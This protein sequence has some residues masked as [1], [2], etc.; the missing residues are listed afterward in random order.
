MKKQWTASF[1]SVAFIISNLFFVMPILAA[2]ENVK[3]SFNPA[4]LIPSAEAATV[5][6]TA[7]GADERITLD[8]KGVDILDVLKIIGQRTQMNVIAGKNVRGEV[9]LFLNDVPI[10]EALDTI[11]STLDLSYSQ[12]G[13]IMNVMSNQAFESAYG[14]S[15]ESG[16]VNQIV[17]IRYLEQEDAAKIIDQLKTPRG[18]V[19]FDPRSNSFLI[20]D[21]PMNVHE[22]EKK[23]GELDKPLTTEVFKIQY[24]NSTALMTKLQTY[25]TPKVGIMNID[26]RT[27][28]IS[29][30]DR[31]EKMDTVR[32][33][34][35]AFDIAPRQVLLEAKLVE[36]GLFDSNRSGIDWEFIRTSLNDFDTISLV[37]DF[38]LPAPSSAFGGTVL[39]SFTFTGGA[40]G[41]NTVL[42]L[43]QNVG[44]TDTISSPRVTVLNNEEAK[45]VDATKQ[46]YVSQTVSQTANTSQTADN[47]QFVDVGVSLTVIPTIAD[48]ETLVLR[49]K[50]EV[51]R[52]TP[53]SPLTLQSVASGSE[54]TFTRTSVPI[55]A[56]QSLETTV[57]VKSGQTLV[58]GGLMKDRTSKRR[59]KLPVISDIPIL[60]QAFQSE[61][62]DYQKTELV[63]FLTPHII[64]NGDSMVV[65]PNL[66][67][68]V[69]DPKIEGV[70]VGDPGTVLDR[71][72]EPLAGGSR[73]P[74]WKKNNQ[75]A[76][77]MIHSIDQQQLTQDYQKIL[78]QEVRNRLNRSY[79]LP[80][81][82]MDAIL[83]LKLSRDGSLTKASF[84]SLSG[85]ADNGLEYGPMLQAIERGGVFPAIPSELKGSELVFDIAL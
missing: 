76:D 26:E 18:K 62:L 59:G 64:G 6:P 15:S 70:V 44:K 7:G 32:K 28:Q 66:D 50:P 3:D 36:V 2:D 51:S 35:K 72:A 65:S 42:Q 25:L 58:V 68:S 75:E 78:T 69:P 12:Q 48:D 29:I 40:K 11:L 57:M 21:R 55:V 46:P 83:K 71:N 61:A 31:P 84:E 47:V 19:T 23:L 53:E 54:T 5:Q 1:V 9:T 8:L 43:L 13:Q 38:N 79:L 85:N 16:Y 24:A 37:P 60:G 20:T 67:I 82:K 56:S 77:A 74:Y 73:K 34:V 63:I 10:K 30:S 41:M 39:S 81:G 27:N 52:E 80:Q 33:V 17:H 49:M 22:I 45:L 14:L 4:A